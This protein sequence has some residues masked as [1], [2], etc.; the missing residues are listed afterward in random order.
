VGRAL[1]GAQRR[2]YNRE[3]NLAFDNPAVTVRPSSDLRHRGWLFQVQET[4]PAFRQQ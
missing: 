4:L 1:H 3:R 2:G